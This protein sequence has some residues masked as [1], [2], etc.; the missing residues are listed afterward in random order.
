LPASLGELPDDEGAFIDQ[1]MAVA[2]T[3]KFGAADYQFV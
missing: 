2:E 1:Q 3:T